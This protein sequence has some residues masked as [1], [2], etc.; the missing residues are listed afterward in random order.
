MGGLRWSVVLEGGG[1]GGVL[2]DLY[3]SERICCPVR[4]KPYQNYE[5]K[6]HHYMKVTFIGQL[7]VSQDV[8]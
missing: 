1:G 8:S 5:M 2:W 4:S 7:V 6:S 3:K